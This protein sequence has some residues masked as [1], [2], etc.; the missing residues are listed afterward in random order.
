MRSAECGGKREER[1][2]KSAEWT[3]SPGRRGAVPYIFSRGRVSD[4]LWMGTPSV[5]GADSS[6]YTREP[7]GRSYE[8]AYGTDGDSSRPFLLKITGKDCIINLMA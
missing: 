7:E 2:G 4:K 8:G 1:R 6:L 5:G 3:I